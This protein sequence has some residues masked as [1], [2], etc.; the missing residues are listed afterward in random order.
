MKIDKIIK[1]KE[2]NMQYESPKG[3]LQVDVPIKNM[4]LEQ[5][6]DYVEDIRVGLTKI[7]IYNDYYVI[8]TTNKVSDRTEI[9]KVA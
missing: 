8:I 7:G 1:I 9:L 5:V 2:K 4:P 6:K 3:V